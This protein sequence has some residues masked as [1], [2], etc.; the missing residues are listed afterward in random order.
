MQP[1]IDASAVIDS[2]PILADSLRN[3][4]TT[5]CDSRTKGLVMA[6]PQNSP[7]GIY[8]GT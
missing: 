1:Y 6:N 7:V 3:A 5:S 4:R 2:A 8:S